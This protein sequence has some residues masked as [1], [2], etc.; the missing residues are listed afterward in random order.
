MTPDELYRTVMTVDPPATE[1]PFEAATREFLFGQVWNRPGLS[2]RDRRLV[3]LACVAAADAT[4]PIDDHVYA[5]LRS[6]DLTIEQLNEATLHFAVYCGWPKASHLETTV[7]VQWHR[8]HAE[9]GEQPE[10]WPTLTADDLGP[11]DRDERI[12]LGQKE[13]VDVNGVPAPPSD[14]P[15]F[16]SGI[17]NFVFGHV[18][19][20]P[21]LSRRD[22]RLVT[23]PCVGLSDAATPIASHVGSALETGDLTYDEMQEIILQFSAYY[24]FAKGQA[25]H[26]AA[27]RWRASKT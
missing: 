4:G 2:I 3:S 25:L 20:R 11:A 17:L 24:G 18:W 22:R 5:A 19:R 21:G 16:H 10:P 15:Y 7:R 1:T 6:A 26:D 14:S 12:S 9:R 27:E 23:I 8:V 13:F